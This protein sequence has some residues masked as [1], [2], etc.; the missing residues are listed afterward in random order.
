MKDE[1]RGGE[2]SGSEGPAKPHTV[3]M[4]GY[5]SLKVWC[6][7]VFGTGSYACIVC[8]CSSAWGECWWA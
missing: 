7:C 5:N 8:G 3:G 1:E 2:G 6:A 4:Q